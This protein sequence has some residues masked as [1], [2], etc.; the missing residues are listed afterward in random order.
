MIMVGASLC[1]LGPRLCSRGLISVERHERGKRNL[2]PTLI[3]AVERAVGSCQR[4][5]SPVGLAEARANL[6]H[7][8]QFRVNDAATLLGVS[9]DTV[10]RWVDSGRLRAT[11]DEHGHR[12]VDGPDLAAF[13]KE[14]GRGEA[15]LSTTTGTTTSSARNRLPGIVTDVVR[16]GVM[17]QVELQTGPFR[18][19]S[20]MSREAADA[21]G[22]EPGVLAVASIKATNVVV[23]RLKEQGSR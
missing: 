18:I 2:A 23:E 9:G 7:M 17:A 3:S 19:V 6:L 20:L 13:V 5:K 12:I 16:D 1:G 10:R 21:L 8:S 14:Y 11:R 22:L 4:A 15:A